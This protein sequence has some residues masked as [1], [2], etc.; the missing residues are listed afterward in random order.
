MKVEL[1]RAGMERRCGLNSSS[2]GQRKTCMRREGLGVSWEV[3]SG[4]W[5][6][7]RRR[8]GFSQV[9]EEEEVWRPWKSQGHSSFLPARRL[10]LP[11][12]S[13]SPPLHPR[14]SCSRPIMA[15]SPSFLPQGIIA[16]G[17]PLYFSCFTHSGPC[18]CS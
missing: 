4:F 2:G 3:G 16:I 10:L 18:S 8:R 1:E 12:S 5:G 9:G 7:E 17:H 13:P 6:V 15:K 14:P 11:D